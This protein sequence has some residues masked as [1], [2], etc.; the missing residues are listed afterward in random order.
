MVGDE[1]KNRSLG[2]V[3]PKA[4]YYSDHISGSE[5]EDYSVCKV[6]GK[7]HILGIGQ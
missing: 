1:V 2:S 4:S 7:L 5:F 3:E 6:V